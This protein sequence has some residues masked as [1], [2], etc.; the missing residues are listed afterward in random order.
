MLRKSS[1]SFRPCC[2]PPR[3]HVSVYVMSVVRL[4]TLVAR[5]LQLARPRPGKGL[6]LYGTLR[7]AMRNR[8][9]SLRYGH[10]HD[11][12]QTNSSNVDETKGT[13]QPPCGSRLQRSLTCVHNRVRRMDA[14]FVPCAQSFVRRCLTMLGLCRPCFQEADSSMGEKRSE[15]SSLR[16]C[17]RGARVWSHLRRRPSCEGHGPQEGDGQP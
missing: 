6:T 16:E 4:S 1:R 17:L 10:N 8:T 2:R 11:V 12:G 14:V 7:K 5:V 15:I 3:P 9:S 13:A